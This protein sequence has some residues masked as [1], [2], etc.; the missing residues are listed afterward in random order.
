MWI[1]WNNIHKSHVLVLF[2]DYYWLIKNVM[3]VWVIY[4]KLFSMK[5]SKSS[6][7]LVVRCLFCPQTTLFMSL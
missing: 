1:K 2:Y 7:C 4:Y 5:T 3:D 6:Q